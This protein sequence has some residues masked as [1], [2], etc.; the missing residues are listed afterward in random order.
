MAKGK[1]FKKLNS[2]RTPEERREIARKGGI[3]SGEARR[4][5]KTF[6]EIF[7]TFLSMEFADKKGGITSGVEAMGMKVVEK[8][9][10][11][12]LRAFELIR[13]TVGE[14]PVEKIATVE[15]PDD[16]RSKVEDLVNEYESENSIQGSD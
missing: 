2:E 6:S 4:K 16:V 12:D 8:A 11:G 9:M 1:D 10:K 5:R 3:A 15:I 14:K 13:D 7:D